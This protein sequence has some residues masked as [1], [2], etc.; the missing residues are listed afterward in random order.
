MANTEK[1]ESLIPGLSENF[2]PKKLSPGQVATFRLVGAG[3]IDPANDKPAFN[4]GATF[5]GE[6]HIYDPKTGNLVHLQ[7]KI[8]DEV[9]TENGQ[10]R[11]V[12]RFGPIEFNNY[13]ICKVKHTEPYKYLFMMLHNANLTNKYRDPSVTPI[14]EQVIAV[15]AVQKQRISIE[16]EYD[17]ITIIKQADTDMVL[18]IGQ[19]LAKKG[20]FTPNLSG[21]IGDVRYDL[22]AFAKKDPRAVILCS[23]DEEALAKVNIIMAQDYEAIEFNQAN[24]AWEWVDKYG[25]EKEIYSVEPGIDPIEALAKFMLSQEEDN[26]KAPGEKKKTTVY[27]EIKDTLKSFVKAEV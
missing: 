14:W 2:I 27:K 10:R 9:I 18:S 20:L 3:I 11:V 1:Y 23:K 26:K 25:K 5:I 22:I 4:A 15:N 21:P 12:S 7:N 13:G 16:L 6:T 17:A 19:S 24:N 8:G